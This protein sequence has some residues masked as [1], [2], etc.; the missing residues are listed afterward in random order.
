MAENKET[1]EHFADD[2]EKTL[3]GMF[4]WIGLVLLVFGTIII[5]LIKKN[6]ENFSVSTAVISIIVLT[7]ISFFLIFFFKIRDKTG[8]KIEKFQTNIKLPQPVAKETLLYKFKN[9][10]LKNIDFFNEVKS[11]TGTYP[12]PIGSNLIYV[13]EVESAYENSKGNKKYTIIYNANFPNMQPAI[14]EDP[15]PQILA[16]RINNMSTKPE[17]PEEKETSITFNPTTG[18][19]T[20]YSKTGHQKELSKPINKEGKL[21]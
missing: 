2:S 16:K 10:E 8:K 19:T 9:E 7:A 18:A 15:T 21:E 5:L 12:T 4:V 17:G 1:I 14:L 11:I 6:V 3:Q 20:Q 13:F